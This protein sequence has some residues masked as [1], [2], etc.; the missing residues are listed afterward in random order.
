L[1]VRVNA[2]SLAVLL[3]GERLLVVGTGL[4]IVKVSGADAPPN[5]GVGS[6]TVTENVP[7]VT[8]SD[9][10]MGTVNWVESTKVVVRSTPSMPITKPSTK[11]MPLTASVKPGSPAVALDGERLLTIGAATTLSVLVILVGVESFT[12]LRKANLPKALG[13]DGLAECV[14]CVETAG[15]GAARNMQINAHVTAIAGM[16]TGMI[17]VR[18]RIS[19][20]LLKDAMLAP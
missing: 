10:A 4:L 16:Q 3:V 18:L 15:I 5:R 17:L 1:T 2:A 8:I 11:P 19:R 13:K 20:F 6:T 9:A 14:D 12:A 7:A